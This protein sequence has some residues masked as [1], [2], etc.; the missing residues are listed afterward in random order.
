[1]P[2]GRA[3]ESNL[4][5]GSKGLPGLALSETLALGMAAIAPP[6]LPSDDREEIRFALAMN[7]GVSL[8]VWM[9]GVMHELDRLRR[10]E[11]LWGEILDLTQ[12]TARVDVIAGASAG[13]LNG[14]FL[15]LAIACNTDLAGMRDLWLQRGSFGKLLRDPLRSDPPSLLDGDHVFLPS[16][17]SVFEA[18]YA[19][20]RKD[21]DPQAL[22]LI[23]TATTLT[24]E[25]RAFPDASGSLIADADHRARFTFR[26]DPEADLDD[27]APAEAPAQLALAART[28]ASFPGAF[29]PSYVPVGSGSA[30]RPDMGRVSSFGV[31]RYAI[32]GGVLVNL[33]VEPMLSAI[34]RRSGRGQVRR[35]AAVIVPSPAP[36]EP[37]PADPREDVPTIVEVATSGMSR[38]PRQQSIGEHLEQIEEHN[39]RVLERRRRR[40][41]LLIALDAA[42][43]RELAERL[44]GAYLR[45]RRADVAQFVLERIVAAAGPAHTGV[46]L[47]LNRDAIIAA[48][49]SFTNPPWL[50]SN[51]QMAA[52]L[53]GAPPGVGVVW[54]WG[55]A[56]VER[57]ATVVLDVL[58]HALLLV[59]LERVA[60]RRALR[61]LR[62]SA[63]RGLR[64]LRQVRKAE[65]ELWEGSAEDAFATGGDASALAIWVR[66]AADRWR[67][68]IS[69]EIL[70]ELAASLADELAQGARLI[71][72]LRDTGVAPLGSVVD[73]LDALAPE[74]AEPAAA[75]REALSSLLALEIVERALGPVDTGPAQIIELIQVSGNA[76]NA[77]DARTRASE[78]LAG[79]QLEHF[80]AFYK[81]SWRA[82]DWLWGRLDGIAQLVQVLLLPRRLRQLG[83]SAAQATGLVQTIALDGAQPSDAEV[84]RGAWDGSAIAAELAYLDAPRTRP[85]KTLPGVTRAL[86]RRLQLEVLQEEIPIVARCVLTDV[87]DGGDRSSA[88]H[89]ARRV[90]EGEQLDARKAVELFQANEVGKERISDEVGS[91]LFSRV[92][93][94]ALATAMTALRGRHSGLIGPL[95]SAA[96][97]GRGVALA[98]YLIARGAVA[99]SKTGSAVVAFALAVAGAIVAIPV[100]TGTDPWG[101]LTTLAAIV[102]AAG[103]VLAL[104]RSG[105]VVV[106]LLAVVA[107]TGFVL[108]LVGVIGNAHD[109]PWQRVFGWVPDVGPAIPVVVIVGLAILL[110]LLRKPHWLRRPQNWNR[111]GMPGI[112]RRGHRP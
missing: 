45:V 69:A 67:R 105:W 43:L 85:P 110:G 73:S 109:S 28:S 4:S 49:N 76:P 15:A 10:G 3:S 95:R 16:V 52:F 47:N 66:A 92:S 98:T 75:A 107:A 5:A 36:F 112:R 61:D 39:R 42:Q 100:I 2:R 48:L 19:R 70:A 14:A 13:G 87:A 86:V 104:I 94:K 68:E 1:M 97:A 21:P 63:H 102:L 51:A 35:V 17:R 81:V 62:E 29:E 91:D 24:G 54:P 32:D 90:R 99:R 6:S 84:L 31:S 40:D 56:P 88:G 80:G 55:I 27:F 106:G 60:D 23:V 18:I 11:G 34:L 38:L 72:A 71:R 111:L 103:F 79:L 89:W 12:S 96:T 64:A 26:R 22:D 44:G 65:A 101:A 30:D 37:P 25:M 57:A 33:P 78:K 74:T 8:A 20:R 46:G 108:A 53:R 82:N 83:Y 77:F 9:G 59:P 7:G 58:R 41:E 93:T 50:P